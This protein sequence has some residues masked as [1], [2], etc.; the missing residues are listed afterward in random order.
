MFVWKHCSFK[1]KKLK[2]TKQNR[3]QIAVCDKM[4]LVFWGLRVWSGEAVTRYSRNSW[5]C[6]WFSWHFKVLWYGHINSK[7]PFEIHTAQY[8][9]SFTLKGSVLWKALLSTFRENRAL[10]E[11]HDY[12]EQTYKNIQQPGVC[13]GVCVWLLVMPRVADGHSVWLMALWNMKV[14][15]Q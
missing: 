3:E 14:L 2:M 11:G 7:C 5:L 12:W 13:V 6:Q 4:V 1:Q 8:M 15:C 10:A 9:T